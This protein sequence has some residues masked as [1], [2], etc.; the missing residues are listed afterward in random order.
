MKKIISLIGGITI[1]GLVAFILLSATTNP[2]PTFSLNDLNGK[3]INNSQLENKVTLINFWFPSCPGCV[4]EMPKLRKMAH[5]YQGKDF[6]ILGIAVPIDP[7]DSVKN[8]VV[9][10]NIPFTVMFDDS[11]MVTR[12][13]IKNKLYPTSILINKKGE[14]LQTFVGEPNFKDLYFTVD[15]ELAK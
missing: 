4:S 12:A 6:Q 10:R 9:E 11:E 14:I 3:T 8:Y 15:A 1:I 5:D 13:F 7:L 2:A